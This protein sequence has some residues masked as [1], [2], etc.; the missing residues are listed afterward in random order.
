MKDIASRVNLIE[1]FANQT[2]LLALNA[3]IEAARV[4]EA[5]AGFAV[6]AEAVRNLAEQSQK[7]AQEIGELAVN[8][9]KI[10]EGAGE[11]VGT[12]SPD[13][14]KTAD[15]ISEIAAATE[16]TGR[17]GQRDKK[18]YGKFGYCG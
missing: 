9:V 3:M 13:I 2:D 8:S 15:L 16:R 14:K 11:L 1:E 5:G 4:G 18:F 10:A 17:R 12:V 7:S 6:V